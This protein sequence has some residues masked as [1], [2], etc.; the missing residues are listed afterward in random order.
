MAK[1][2]RIACLFV[3]AA[4]LLAADAQKI[5]SISPTSGGVKGGT[6][7]T[8][9][10]ESF[11]ARGRSNDIYIGTDTEGVFCDPIPNECH[12]KRIVCIT[13]EFAGRGSFPLSVVSFGTVA[14]CGPS[15]GCTFS[16]M[17]DYTPAVTGVRP[18]F[19]TEPGA[20][21]VSG[22]NFA[23]GDDTVGSFDFTAHLGDEE[24]CDLGANPVS[25][26]GFVCAVENGIFPGMNPLN[27]QLGTRGTATGSVG[28]MVIPSV[29]G[30]SAS[31]GSTEGG[32]RVTVTG[33]FFSRVLTENVVTIHGAECT[34][35]SV[36]QAQL[37]CITGKHAPT[38]TKTVTY[39]TGAKMDYW[40]EGT[41]V[42][43]TVM[44]VQQT[45]RY[46][47]PDISQT[48]PAFGG[49]LGSAEYC[50]SRNTA[51]FAPDVTGNYT[52]AVAGDDQVELWLGTDEN[53][54]PYV[55]DVA[56]D[57]INFNAHR[58]AYLTSYTNSFLTYPEQ[59]S[60]PKWLVAGQK[61]WMRTFT[62]NGVGGHSASVRVQKPNGEFVVN[63]TNVYQANTWESPVVVTSRGIRS[64][65]ASACSAFGSCNFNYV[66]SSAT[67]TSV[68]ASAAAGSAITI[69]GTNLPTVATMVSVS[70]GRYACA[71]TSASTTQ[72]VCTTDAA[73][74]AGTVPVVVTVVGTGNA[75]GEIK[76]TIGFSITSAD[77]SKG[78]VTLM[79]NGVAVS[80]DRVSVSVGGSPC[81]NVN[82]AG[83]TITCAPASS[84]SS[85][86][87]TATVTITDASTTVASR[88]FTFQ[89]TLVRPGTTT[90]TPMPALMT[91]TI[92]TGSTNTIEL[93][94][95]SWAINNAADVTVTF[96]DDVCRV[97][98]AIGSSIVCE[99]PAI[100]DVQSYNVTA[101]FGGETLAIG[102]VSVIETVS[103]IDQSRISK[104]G[105]N[106]VEIYYGAL[107]IPT[108]V[109]IAYRGVPC[110]S[111]YFSQGSFA[112]CFID[113]ASLT[114]TVVLPT[115]LSASSTTPNVAALLSMSPAVS[116]IT[117]GF[118][119][120]K[121]S[122]LFTRRTFDH[123]ITVSAKVTTLTSGSDCAIMSGLSPDAS[124]KYGG[125][126]A[127]SNGNADNA[128]HI[129]NSGYS[130]TYSKY[131]EDASAPAAGTTQTWVLEIHS[132][133]ARFFV[134]GTLMRVMNR[135]WVGTGRV[136]FPVQCQDIRVE[137]LKVEDLR[138]ATLTMTVDGRTVAM[139]DEPVLVDT[140]TMDVR[141]AS[142]I[143]AAGG[144]LTLT[145][146][147]EG[148]TRFDVYAFPEG[149]TNFQLSPDVAQ[150]CSNVG[151]TGNL[152][153]TLY[154]ATCTVG[155]VAGGKFILRIVT[156]NGG[157]ATAQFPITILPSIES[158][159]STGS[160][161]GGI[162]Q[163]VGSGFSNV[164]SDTTITINGANCP[165]VHS[166]TSFAACEYPAAT[167]AALGPF[168]VAVSF[169]TT[170]LSCSNCKF[171]YMS[172][173][174]SPVVTSVETS[175]ALDRSDRSAYVITGTGLSAGT[176]I[177]SGKVCESWW[178][179]A[180]KSY[181]AFDNIA[182][183][184][185]SYT[186][187]YLT[188]SG[189][190]SIAS[191]VK[192]TIASATGF[193]NPA[194]TAA[195]GGTDITV[196][197]GTITP[198]KG[199]TSV[200]SF[201]FSTGNLEN[202]K[203]TVSEGKAT[204]YTCGSAFSEFGGYQSF[205]GTTV[206][207]RDITGLSAHTYISLALRVSVHSN[208]NED[209]IVEIDGTQHRLNSNTL[210]CRD[211]YY[212]SSTCAKTTRAD[213]LIDTVI[214]VPHTGATA[215]IKL[216]LDTY[217]S[218]T[219]R[220]WGVVSYDIRT[221]ALAYTATV[222]GANCPIVKAT[223]H[224]VVCTAPS[225]SGV[226]TV[227]IV[228]GATALPCADVTQCQVTYAAANNLAVKA[229]TY[230]TLSAASSGK[231]LDWGFL[232][233]VTV[234]NGPV[235][236]ITRA[237]GS[238]WSGAATSLQRF[239]KEDMFAGVKFSFSG[240]LM[241]GI[242]SEERRDNTYADI[243]FAFYVNGGAISLYRRGDGLGNV[244]SVNS[245]TSAYIR[246]LENDAVV[247]EIAGQSVQVGRIT[248][249]PIRLDAALT[250][251]GSKLWDI[252]P[253]FH[254]GAPAASTQ[255][256]VAILGENLPDGA[257]VTLDG[258]AC[259]RVY[260]GRD[261][262]VCDL[263]TSATASGSSH[264]VSLTS[265][266]GATTA[267]KTLKPVVTGLSASTGSSSGNHV[268]T[269]LGGGFTGSIVA[270]IGASACTIVSFSFGEIVCI[271]PAGSGS[272][273]VSV[274]VG[275]AP[276]ECASFNRADAN[277]AAI[278]YVCPSYT[279]TAPA[280]TTTAVSVSGATVTLTGTGFPTTVSTS[281]VMLLGTTRCPIT[282]VSATQVTCDATKIACLL[283]TS[284]AAD[285]EDS[286][287]LGGR[288]IIKKKKKKKNTPRGNKLFKTT[289]SG[290]RKKKKKIN[291]HHVTL[292]H[293]NSLSLLPIFHYLY[294]YYT[295]IK[296]LSIQKYNK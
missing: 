134:D 115:L 86:T 285:E 211:Q 105:G 167:G 251:S 177:V 79:G 132:G 248:S 43:Q 166:T 246:V 270:T 181:C 73:A 8:I 254:A 263:I 290:R 170:V 125:F 50:L 249:W 129:A 192:F 218:A 107:R 122:Y 106:V 279:Y 157:F 13:P 235:S 143:V 83:N 278:T 274:T 66:S 256:S 155:D 214:A 4:M 112:R 36:T 70:T 104:T 139:L 197:A 32:Q 215:S 259:D 272:Q 52:F 114:N 230:T 64:V 265:A 53:P 128:F 275:G 23:R 267:T 21:T 198:S 145:L 80:T 3:A 287:D 257:M 94:V 9:L 14:T 190:A 232:N 189:Y 140:I 96:G 141:T 288:R 156:N 58:I 142:S 5:T 38:T 295:N 88:A 186:F 119:I 76:T 99:A 225:G 29:T 203:W 62:T 146:G 109:I 55:K 101:T 161:N 255:T 93:V 180:T 164:A 266:N 277:T 69:T 1:S 130:P 291:K 24:R 47:S 78:Y 231:R 168:T 118:K 172:A 48:A 222:A 169:K 92:K 244:F 242:T 178:N 233:A 18:E 210:Q 7:L 6:R 25:S 97:V 2:V 10:G 173:A 240:L 127:Y 188:A 293:K 280:T 296:L 194:T 187:K 213:C 46:L 144:T 72:I 182:P 184:P 37:V 110:K 234:T 148:L 124:S 12:D 253:L 16:Y 28:V 150:L 22:Y 39:T 219:D 82:I 264:T 120:P 202:S 241:F 33:N 271:V 236:S 84:V 209:F 31:Q 152:A 60:E 123:A 258:S 212:L 238:G 273:I 260:S 71:V 283:Y 116:V 56:P 63:P 252:E 51:L 20:L 74:A 239:R 49:V 117:G 282:S 195:A 44:T 201:D 135:G 162:I 45:L 200:A 136:G 87:V 196:N 151:Y 41:M 65:A 15:S 223:P 133:G 193:A 292:K 17:Y 89:Q 224:A 199:M 176:A 276:T 102:T 250:G 163:V 220:S 247:F 42:G 175:A 262:V 221:G 26:T 217:Y 137:D 85:G 91:K 159:T 229:I 57:D 147:S 90:A 54:V 284:D 228:D 34:P 138:P 226:A 179:S 183:A 205:N 261:I 185:G 19:F 207:T 204:S 294:I 61:Y 216:S 11:D 100:K 121:G 30:I 75:V 108:S 59:Q 103:S 27:L 227:S 208:G 153:G 40:G 111:T 237:S 68:T 268:V 113:D 171:T 206:I 67:V 77:N 154:T 131:A 281:D 160:Y 81:T 98:T 165:V 35:V 269:I 286:V 126:T 149:T 95:Y 245:E 289:L 243:S 158:V 174:N 191:S